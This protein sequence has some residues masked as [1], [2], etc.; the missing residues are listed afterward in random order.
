M[1]EVRDLAGL[2][3][4]DRRRALAAP[5]VP[6]REPRVAGDRRPGEGAQGQ[7]LV[8][9][10][11]DRPRRCAA[12]RT[13]SAG[14]IRSPCSECSMHRSV[15]SADSAPWSGPAISAFG[16]RRARSI[17]RCCA[18]MRAAPFASATVDREP[19]AV[20]HRGDG[21][22]SRPIARPSS[23]PVGQALQQRLRRRRRRRARRPTCPDSSPVRSRCQTTHSPSG[24]ISPEISPTGSLVIWRRSPVAAVPG[25]QLVHAA[26]GRGVDEAIRRVVRPTSGSR[27]WAHGSARCQ[28]GSGVGHGAAA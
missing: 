23:Q 21:P 22:R 17:P 10:V 12:S 7:A 18:S 11:G 8:A 20:A 1:V 9:Q 26:L 2:D 16:R 28:S 25:V 6:D 19:I 5:L 15:S 27:R 14:W 24:V 13:R 4:P 3:V